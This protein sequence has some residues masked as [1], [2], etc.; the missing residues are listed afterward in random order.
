MKKQFYFLTAFLC[1]V[2]CK[3]ETPKTLNVNVQSE[4]H[5]G[6]PYYNIEGSLVYSKNDATLIAADAFNEAEFQMRKAFKANI[7]LTSSDLARIW[8]N[9]IK[10]QIQAMTKGRGR[11]GITGSRDMI[12]GFPPPIVYTPCK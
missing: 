7:N 9:Q 11:A 5:F 8:L 10:L 3:K 1:L 4:V 2:S 12:K 6:L